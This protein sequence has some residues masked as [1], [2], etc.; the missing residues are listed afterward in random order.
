MV[1]EIRDHETANTAVQAAL[2]GHLVLSTLHTKSAVETLERL[3]NIGLASYLLAS[4]VD[5]IIAQRLVRKLCPHCK[6]AY[7]PDMAEKELIEWVMREI[8]MASMIRARKEGYKLYRSNGCEE[9]GNT[10]YKGRIGIY[11]VLAFNDE[12]RK[13]IRSGAAPQDILVMARKQDLILMREDGILKALRGK[14]DLTE[15]F[16]VVE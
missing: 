12:I 4:A 13:A 1:G 10:G 3:L 7:D 15:L 6:I 2:T 11:E 14:I 5:I 8:G 16:R 9:C